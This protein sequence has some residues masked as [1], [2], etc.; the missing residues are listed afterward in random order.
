M[1]ASRITVATVEKTAPEIAA[2][3]RPGVPGSEAPHRADRRGARDEAA[4][5]PR[6]GKSE[7]WPDEPKRNVANAGDAH[8]QDDETP[9]SERIE[10]PVRADFAVGQKG[11]EDDGGGREEEEV[12]HFFGRHRL[13]DEIVEAFACGKEDGD[14]D[15]QARREDGLVV[16]E[17]PEEEGDHHRDF[18]G[19]AR[20]FSRAE[21][22]GDHGGDAHEGKGHGKDG[23]PAKR[24]GHAAE[25]GNQREGPDTGIAPLGAT[26]LAALAL[27]ADE[28]ADGERDGKAQ[29]RF[30][31]A[32][33]DGPRISRAREKTASNI[34]SVRRPV[35][36]FCWLGW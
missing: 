35:K 19:E 6:D 16:G 22:V 28:E 3:R 18:G 5:Q 36:V 23:S 33:G 31:G 4:G 32:Q 14:G 15:A 25:Q 1:T 9:E 17:C 27:E 24:H 10:D 26:A 8:D 12:M 11:E 34:G 30:A 21:R 13:T 20:I 7:P 2:R 29:R